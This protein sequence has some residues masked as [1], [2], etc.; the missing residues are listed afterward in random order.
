MKKEI[1]NFLKI[2]V[3]VIAFIF[4]INTIAASTTLFDGTLS[5]SKTISDLDANDNINVQIDLPAAQYVPEY[6]IVLVVDATNLTLLNTFNSDLKKFLIEELKSNDKVKINVG[7]IVFGTSVSLSNGVYTTT[8][9]GKVDFKELSSL[10]SA[11]ID[12]HFSLIGT[13]AMARALGMKLAQNKN[14]IIGTNLQ[15]GI[16]EGRKLLASGNAPKDNKMMVMLTDGGTYM[17]TKDNETN[18]NAFV[19]GRTYNANGDIINHGTLS[20]NDGY[21]LQGSVHYNVNEMA[22]GKYLSENDPF[23]AFYNGEKSNIEADKNGVKISRYYEGVNGDY[24]VN[25]QLVERSEIS[26]KTLYPY[27]GLEKGIYYAAKELKDM[28][29]KNECK[30]YTVGF[31]YYS[32]HS[33]HLT[34]TQGFMKWTETKLGQKFIPVTSEGDT[35][36]IKEAAKDIN[37]EI[38]YLFNKGTITE[39]I[40]N[41]FNLVGMNTIDIKVNGISQSRTNLDSSTIAFGQANANG[42]YPYLAKYDSVKKTITWTINVPAEK[43]NPISLHHSLH[44]NKSKVAGDYSVY[45]STTEFDYYDTFNMNKKD[46][47]KGTKIS[48]KVRYKAKIIFVDINDPAKEIKKPINNLVI[49][50]SKYNFSKKVDLK[51]EIKVGKKTYVFS[52]YLK[53]SKKLAGTS[54]TNDFVITLAYTDK[55]KTP[56]TGSNYLYVSAVI[57]MVTLVSSAIYLKKYN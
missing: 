14:L 45:P 37:N 15:S 5:G 21:D 17:Y 41:D 39:K 54:P 46:S 7:A 50:N 52:N 27:T 51:K 13:Q 12:K 40:G 26:D 55:S 47:N 42:V 18:T 8:D 44:L 22:Y 31:P 11:E 25:D 32:I 10:T 24:D 28:V 20:Y 35:E 23:D 38:V 19:G 48:Y 2:F 34:P 1:N 36:G 6:D 30:L 16:I 29:D 3:I 56:D 43:D 4:S 57:L 33:S 9:T 53:G 49:N